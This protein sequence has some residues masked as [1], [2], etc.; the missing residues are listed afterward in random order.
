MNDYTVGIDIGTNSIKIIVSEYH[1]KNEKPYILHAIESKS[2]GFRNGYIVDKDEAFNS[3]IHALNKVKKITKK[4]IKKAKFS[5]GGIG[6]ASKYIR[7]NVDIDSENEEISESDIFNLIQKSENLFSQKYPNK[8]ILHII[9]IRYLVDDAPVLG[10]PIGMYGSR[11]EAKIIFITILEHH[12]ESF[13]S[14]IKKT[15]LIIQDIIAAPI[16]DSK[17]SINYQQKSQGCIL[18]NIGSET[19]SISTY[20]NGNITSIK[21]AEI[22]SNDITNDIALGFQVSLDTAEDIKLIKIISFPKQKVKEII[23]ARF[24]DIL[25]I[26]ERHLKSLNKNRMLPAGIIFSGGGSF[27]EYIEEQG[28]ANL[29]LP[30]KKV[31][32]QKYSKKTKRNSN[33]GPQFSIAYG[34]CF[35]DLKRSTFR[36]EFS[37]KKMKQKIKRLF[38]QMMP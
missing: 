30:A 32:I 6:L 12:Y 37:L 15:G 8:K 29:H 20:E 33:I 11:I 17:S 13:I 4:D 31:I 19:S 25:D 28:K 5:I 34:L 38:K 7:T 18:I 27:L 2:Q 35:P 21:I 14:V 24:A 9:P 36:N 16:A 23:Y 1:Q 26:A 10:N 22:G 3:L